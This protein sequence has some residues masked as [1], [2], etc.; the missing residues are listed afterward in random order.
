LPGLILLNPLAMQG[1]AA[2]SSQTTAQPGGGNALA[3][4]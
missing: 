1:A 3:I 2:I 4:V